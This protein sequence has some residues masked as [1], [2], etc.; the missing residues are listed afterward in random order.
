MAAFREGNYISRETA[1]DHSANQYKLVKLDAANKVVL[2]SAA[3][4]AILGVLETV[5]KAGTT[6]SVALVNG[7]GTFKVKTSGAI[8]A[9]QYLTA[10]ASG[11]AVAATQT[12]AG[13]QPTVRV[14]GRAL[15]TSA[16]GDV[17]EYEKKDFLY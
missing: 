9:G 14:F 17:V 6:V 3:T 13:S 15:V 16:S 1:V 2:A 8:T 12:A 4:D 5:G 11:L 10:N 7:N